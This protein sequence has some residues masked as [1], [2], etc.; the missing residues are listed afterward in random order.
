M[1]IIVIS[2]THQNYRNLA[3]IVE[4]Q[5][6]A[7]CFVYLGD[8]ESEYRLL[9][10][11]YPDLA[12]KFHYVRGNCDYN[13]YPLEQVIDLPYGHK[14]YA[15]HGH[16]L[17]VNQTTDYLIS[18]ALTHNCDIALYG[19]THCSHTEY[20]CGVHIMNPGSASLPRD[21]KAPSYGLID[22]SPAGIL[23]NIVPIN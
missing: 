20:F 22:V 15:V 1:K 7:D 13:P 10:Q 5:Q 23:T 6:D 14:I 9:L 2:D 11:K 8:G 4:L 21:G 16:K 12:E 3:K 17:Q 19:H 18:E